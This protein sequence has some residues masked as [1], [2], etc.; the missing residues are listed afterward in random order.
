LPLARL[1]ALNVTY[2]VGFRVI[3]SQGCPALGAE[4]VLAFF[5]VLFSLP[6]VVVEGQHLLVGQAAIGGGEADAG[7]QFARMELDLGN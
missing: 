6:P 5:D 7:E 1:Q 2:N 4:R 3:L